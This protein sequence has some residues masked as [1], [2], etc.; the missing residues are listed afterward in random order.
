MTGVATVWTPHISPLSTTT[1]SQQTP[2]SFLPRSLGRGERRATGWALFVWGGGGGGGIVAAPEVP[3]NVYLH[4]SRN[5]PQ[6]PQ[7]E[8][9][10]R[11][12][13]SLILRNKVVD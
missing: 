5:H 13:K 7:A 2:D 4:V 12:A 11:S 6:S 1:T 8:V 9:R 3:G 10:Q